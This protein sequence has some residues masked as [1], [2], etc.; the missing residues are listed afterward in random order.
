ML[1]CKRTFKNVVN[2]DFVSI[3]V[4]KQHSLTH[5]Q[6]KQTSKSCIFE[7]IN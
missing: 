4:H 2:C 3:H 1:V 6:L 5:K 7:Y